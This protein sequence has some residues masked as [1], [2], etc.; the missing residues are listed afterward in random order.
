MPLHNTE[1]LTA[2]PTSPI[3]SEALN[4][5]T[6]TYEFPATNQDPQAV[7]QT[8]HDQLVLDGNSQQ[9]LATFCTTWIEAEVKQRVVVLAGDQSHVAAVHGGNPSDRAAIGDV[10]AGRIQGVAAFDRPGIDAAS[11]RVRENA[12]TLGGVDVT[13]ADENVLPRR[14]RD[15]T[16]RRLNGSA[17]VLT[18]AAVQEN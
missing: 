11:Q 2:A 3:E 12:A 13:A 5:K 7:Y 1:T 17:Q 4:A 14:Q 9:N 18:S 10:I 15:G 6:L 8:I 16:L